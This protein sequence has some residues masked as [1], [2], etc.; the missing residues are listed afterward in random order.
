MRTRN[1]QTVTVYKDGR[2]DETQTSSYERWWS[3]SNTDKGVTTYTSGSS[4][5]S[6]TYRRTEFKGGYSWSETIS[7]TNTESV[8]KGGV[9]TSKQTNWSWTRSGT[10]WDDGRNNWSESWSKSNWENGRSVPGESETARGSY[11]PKGTGTQ[12]NNLP[13]AGEAPRLTKPPKDI[14]ELNK[15]PKYKPQPSQEFYELPIANP[16]IEKKF[17][18]DFFAGNPAPRKPT[19]KEQIEKLLKSGAIANYNQIVGLIIQNNSLE[20]LRSVVG[21]VGM[22]TLIVD[23]FRQKPEMATA[24]M[25]ALLKG[26]QR[27]QNP[28]PNDFVLHFDVDKSSDPM[29]YDANMNCWEMILYAAFLCGQITT[30]QIREFFKRAKYGPGFFSGMP[31]MGY[32]ESLHSMSLYPAANNRQQSGPYNQDN[33]FFIELPIKEIQI[34]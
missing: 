1:G 10:V 27:W 31:M 34:M 3:D 9:T 11:D 18:G 23:K 13:Q 14:L 8:T 15:Q 29:S 22:R 4:T 26:M 19:F 12:T 32:D 24:I 25:A 20:D 16:E 6:S 33:F 2:K 28:A 17:P 5:W 7:G 30:S 21:D